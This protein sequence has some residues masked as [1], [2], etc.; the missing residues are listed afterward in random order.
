MKK[1]D[2]PLHARIACFLFFYHITPQTTTG[3][4]PAELL[5]GHH[6]HSILDFTRRD[7][8]KQVPKV[9]RRPIRSF[10]I[11]NKLFARIFSVTPLCIPVVVCNVTGPL[12]YQVETR[13]GIILKHHS[14]QLK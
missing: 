9:N 14:D 5:F 4:S 1:M 10:E 7:A 8:T 11:G 2:G 13:D 12:S 3:C 6:P